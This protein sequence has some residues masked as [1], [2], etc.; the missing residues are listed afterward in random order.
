MRPAGPPRATYRLQVSAALPMTAVADL[1]PYLRDLGISHLYASPLMQARRGSTHGYDVVDPTRFDEERGGEEGFAALSGALDEHGLGLLL[2]VVPNHAAAT[3]ENPWWRDVLAR[4]HASPHAAAFDIDWEAPGLDGKVL[5]PL[6]GEPYGEA[7]EGGAVRVVA[8]AD[9]EREGDASGGDGG[10]C[11][12]GRSAFEIAYHEYRLPLSPETVAEVAS[13]GVEA[14]AGD[15][16][17]ER[18]DALLARQH[19]RLAFW[20]LA[21]ERLDYRRFF[22]VH[23]LVGL[24]VEVPEVFDAV[25]A[26][27]LALRRAGLVQGLRIDHVDGLRQP[28]EHLRRLRAALHEAAPHRGECYV[29]VEKILAAG[30]DLRP[31]WSCHG[32][33]GYD[34]DNEVAALFVEPEG[35]AELD[36]VWRAATGATRRFADLRYARKKLVMTKLFGAEISRLARKL[37]LLA[38]EDRSARDLPPRSL[39]AALTEVTACLPVYRTYVDENGPDDA[40]HERLLLA[41][42][43][44]K[45]RTADLAD[46]VLP[47]ALGFLRRV[48]RL[49]LPAH[50]ADRRARWLD[51]VQDW[52]QSTGAVMAKGH[53]DTALYVHARLLSLN[54]V[55]GEPPGVAP[56][57]DVDAFHRANAR[58]RALWP[59]TMNATTTHDTKRS[60]DAGCRISALSEMPAEWEA[61]TGRW[62]ADNARLQRRLPDGR[63]APDANEQLFLYQT[64]LGAWP[65][66]DA[67]QSDDFGERIATYMRKALRE[68]KT[69]SSWLQPDEAYEEAVL[70][71]AADLLRDEAANDFL[72]AFRALAERLAAV[73]AWSSL[74]QVVLKIASPGIPDF[75]QGTELWDLSLAD[76][77]NRRP[78]DFARR[79]EAL[80]DLRRRYQGGEGKRSAL[81]AELLASWR[82]GRVK[83]FTTWR[84][85]AARA[86]EPDLLLAGDYQALMPE[87]TLARP[88]VAF[89]RAHEGRW[90]LALVPRWVSALVRAGEPPIGPAT[91]ADTWLPLPPESPLVWTDAFT[92]AE[93]RSE[94]HRGG[95]RLAAG[96]ALASFPVALL[97][98][99]DVERQARPLP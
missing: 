54:E 1:V 77:D 60:E 72:P 11:I 37:L 38:A 78:V 89:A 79:R 90:L 86:A 61:M 3:A 8:R 52:Q 5:V 15:A 35:F 20:R 18:L 21:G 51:F 42:E 80:A 92:G 93:L 74:A 45:R 40:D 57:G 44:A 25:H 23:D 14:Y 75:Y 56:P 95:R 48:L 4:G 63:L 91:W 33:T 84:A 34:F 66:D 31:D 13:N 7:L 73:G 71:F 36:R 96:I 12:A 70:G 53:E 88:L 76:P 83:L 97:L 43:D 68:A 55:G 69:H 64:L 59:A 30:E 16:G 10:D 19:Y 39:V 46:P 47:L 99:R 81:I 98:G 32:T 29:V 94:E 87:G 24:R 41:F 22:D 85:L 62:L 26:R 50:L 67:E 58:R 28:G 6:L 2:D 65:L 9:P 82:D 27:L 49:A 17:R